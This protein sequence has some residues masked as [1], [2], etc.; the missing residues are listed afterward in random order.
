[1]IDV[2]SVDRFPALPLLLRGWVQQAD[3]LP[4]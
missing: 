2:A 1:M 4:R 3:P